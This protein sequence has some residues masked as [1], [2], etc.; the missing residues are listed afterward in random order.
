MQRNWNLF[1]RSMIGGNII[2]KYEKLIAQSELYF[3]L[4]AESI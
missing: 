4:P 2:E 3:K 1:G